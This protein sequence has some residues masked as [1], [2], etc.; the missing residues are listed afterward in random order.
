MFPGAPG[1]G[2]Y[3]P[4][5]LRFTA[6]TTRLYE[7]L[8]VEKAATEADIK[9]AYRKLAVR[10]H[11]DKGGDPERFREIAGAYEVLSDP[12]KRAKYDEFGEEGLEASFFAPAPAAAAAAPAEPQ[13]PEAK[14]GGLAVGTC[15]LATMVSAFCG[16]STAAGVA[17]CGAGHALR[18]GGSSRHRATAVVLMLGGGLLLWPMLG[19]LHGWSSV[20]WTAAMYGA[21]VCGLGMLAKQWERLPHFLPYLL[22]VGYLLLFLL[23][24]TRSS[25]RMLVELP[26]YVVITDQGEVESD[27][28]LAESAA[29]FTWGV[30]AIHQ[31]LACASSQEGAHKRDDGMPHCV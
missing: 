16:I 8:E 26:G 27:G 13:Q 12:E 25:E 22:L 11:P 24:P 14:G 15:V 3:E 30:V 9:K 20:M 5:V 1:D 17:L 4:S 29:L 23:A 18:G 31:I 19:F 21:T 28:A 6:D 7:V 10:H 2:G